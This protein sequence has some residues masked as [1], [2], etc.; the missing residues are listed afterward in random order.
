MSKE[1]LLKFMN[2]SM[3]INIEQIPQYSFIG[4]NIKI[5]VSGAMNRVGT[6]TIAMNM[7]SY[8][9]SIGAK[10]SYTEANGNNHLEKNPFL[11]LFQYPY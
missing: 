3:D 10:V 8:L 2:T 9:A 5:I 1:Y 11:F 6:T 7:V 4:E